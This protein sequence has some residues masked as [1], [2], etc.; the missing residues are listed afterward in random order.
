MDRGYVA[1]RN[2]LAG[3]G[4]ASHMGKVRDGKLGIGLSLCFIVAEA[5]ILL[6]KNLIF[7]L[8]Q[9]PSHSTRG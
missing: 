2:G 7:F 3:S 4:V 6:L 1:C 9:V 5:R 8:L